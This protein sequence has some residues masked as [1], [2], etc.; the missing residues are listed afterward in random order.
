MKRIKYYVLAFVVA[1]LSFGFGGGGGADQ[2]DWPAIYI[3]ASAGDGGDGSQASPYNEFS[4]INWT[5]GGD[6][7]IYDYYDGTPTESVTI[8][9]K[10]GETWRETLTVGESGTATYPI[11]I[12]AYGS[13]NDPIISGADVITTW[14]EHLENLLTNSDF[15]DW[16]D[17]TVPDNWSKGGTHDANNYV[18]ESPADDLHF[19][20]DGTW[21]YIEQLSVLTIGDT[22]NYS[23]KVDTVTSGSIKLRWGASGA[24]TVISSTGTHTGSAVVQGSTPGN[25]TGMI[26]ARNAACNLVVDELIVSNQNYWKATVNTEPTAV[27]FDG[28]FG[29][30]KASVAALADEY[31]WYW[32]SNVLYC[33]ST[34]DPDSAY[35]TILATARASCLDGNDKSY[36]TVDGL[37]L[38]KS[39]TQGIHISGTNAVRP[40]NVIVQ[41]CTLTN[42]DM[43]AIVVGDSA[44]DILT[45]N[46]VTI[47]SCTITDWFRAFQVSGGAGN[48]PATYSAIYVQDGD[49]SGGD[50]LSITD[51]TITGDLAWDGVEAN[52]YRDAAH[53]ETGDNI[54][55]TGNEITGSEHG[56]SI[57]GDG[58]S[59]GYAETFT[60]SRN[61][62]H[63]TPDDF[64]FI[65][66]TGVSDSIISYNLMENTGSEAIHLQ[67]CA[68]N[69]SYGSIYNNTIYRTG[70]AAI[71]LVFGCDNTNFKNNVILDYGLNPSQA[72]EAAAFMLSTNVTDMTS[73]DFDYNLIY[74]SGDTTQ[75]FWETGDGYM[76]M[77]TYRTNYSQEANSISSDPLLTDPANADFTLQATSPCI[78]A[79]TD[80]SLTSDY[81]S[82][83]VPRMGGTATSKVFRHVAGN[84]YLLVGAVTEGAPDIGAYERVAPYKYSGGHLYMRLTDKYYLRVSAPENHTNEDNDYGSI[85]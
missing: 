53:I 20:S 25:A 49:G 46:D 71:F 55:I 35:T 83:S 34:T 36:I 30:K 2:A 57:R 70:H 40:T 47:D 12:Q 72:G 10:K 15:V 38:T 7:S 4:D 13:G 6:N 41:N 62:F 80:V 26:I 5:T 29:D 11:V 1:A 45:P 81:A 79:G 51:C 84:I 76:S 21:T 74:K 52:N 19:V 54:T 37:N 67:I 8:N 42:H 60:I 59:A 39:K 64:I 78:D 17:A 68:S 63:D 65:D 24:D 16:A 22:V 27:W 28:N 50:N 82:A 23:I 56:I 58:N 48:V 3:D 31:D 9:L 61:Y 18:E 77:A 33:Y 66:G 73:N 85:R 14:T 44:A 32:N 75:L 43:A 69:D